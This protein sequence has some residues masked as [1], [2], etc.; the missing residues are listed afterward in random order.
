MTDPTY[1]HYQHTRSTHSLPS[2]FFLPSPPFQPTLSPQVQEQIGYVFQFAREMEA[3]TAQ[4]YRRQKLREMRDMRAAT[5][6]GEIAMNDVGVE[7]NEGA[8]SEM[9]VEINEVGL[10]ISEVGMVEIRSKEVEKEQVLEEENE[11]EE[12]EDRDEGFFPLLSDLTP[13]KSHSGGCGDLSSTSPTRPNTK[14]QYLSTVILPHYI[15]TFV[16]PNA[17]SNTPTNTPPTHPNTSPRFRTSPLSR[18]RRQYWVGRGTILTIWGPLSMGLVVVVVGIEVLVAV[19]V[20]VVVE[21]VIAVVVLGVVLGV[22]LVVV[23]V[24]EVRS[25]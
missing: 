23:L 21:L 9:G 1:K 16:H 22:V 18:A 25:C 7:K 8:I 4:P 24:V 12:E 2:L 10:E 11:K 19:M 6:K 15:H 3:K 14:V 5:K 13:L 20:L 17:P